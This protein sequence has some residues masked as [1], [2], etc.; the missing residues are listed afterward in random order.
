[1][2]LFIAY[3]KNIVIDV[4]VFAV[5]S[6]ARFGVA[7]RR[8]RLVIQTIGGVRKESHLNLIT[9]R[10]NSHKHFVGNLEEL[11]ANCRC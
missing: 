5:P 9:S 4:F 1:M 10:F 11:S 7:G 6:V 2:F 3:E 8:A